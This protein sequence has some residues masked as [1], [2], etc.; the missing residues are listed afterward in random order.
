MGRRS[1]GT[2]CALT[3]REQAEIEEAL[4]A[5]VARAIPE[6]LRLTDLEVRIPKMEVVA[7]ER[8]A[9][10]DGKSIGTVLARE[11]L[12]LRVGRI[13]GFLVALATGRQRRFLSRSATDNFCQL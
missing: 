4:G 2:S 7:L 6:L 9:E 12:G 13:P 11:L 8:V 5:E 3:F 10:R 1:R